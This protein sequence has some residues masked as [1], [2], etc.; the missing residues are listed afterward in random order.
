[1]IAGPSY[2]PQLWIDSPEVY[3]YVNP[4]TGEHVTSLL[5]PDHPEMTCLQEGEHVTETQFG[6]LGRCH[7]GY[8]GFGNTKS[9]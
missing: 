9:H 8:L 7:R 1:M 3:H 4:K 2:V 5:T 6:F